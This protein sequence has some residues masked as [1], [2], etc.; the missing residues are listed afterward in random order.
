MAMFRNAA[1]KLKQ[2]GWG[3]IHMYNFGVNCNAEDVSN[4]L[5]DSI[6]LLN[7]DTDKLLSARVEDGS[8][9][10]NSAQVIYLTVHY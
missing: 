10:V 2:P 7:Y 5:F 8:D 9:V 1:V 6:L 4:E 3:F